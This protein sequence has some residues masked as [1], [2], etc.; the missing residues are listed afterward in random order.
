MIKD[1]QKIRKRRI[2]TTIEEKS[3]KNNTVKIK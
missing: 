1:K 2:K 3:L